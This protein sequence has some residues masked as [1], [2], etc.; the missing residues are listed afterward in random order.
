MNVFVIEEAEQELKKK[1]WSVGDFSVHSLEGPV[2]VVHCGRSD[3]SLRAEGKTQQEAW[4]N[5]V[6]A[7]ENDR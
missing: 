1:G 7:A 2:L 6:N 5:A 4:I 3:E